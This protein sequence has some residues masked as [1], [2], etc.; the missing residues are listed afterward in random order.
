MKYCDTFCGL[1]GFSLGLRA[2]IPDAECVWAIDFDKNV[3]ET[4]KNNFGIECLGN[5]RDAKTENIPDHDI[6]FGGFPC[7]PF[8][9]NGKW[10]NKNDKTIG[11]AEDRDNLF[12]E[13]VRILKDKQ[14]KY[15]VFENV[16]GLLKMK[17]KDGT[18][19]I[20]TI[21]E[22]LVECGQGY[23][24]SPIVVDAA[25]FGVPQQRVRVFLIGI[26]KDLDQEFHWPPKV[27]KTKAIEDILES[28]VP[29]KYLISNIWKNRKIKGGGPESGPGK[30]NHPF[31]IGH[32]RHEVI[33]HIYNEA[34]KPK[35][36]THKIESVAILYGD[37]PSGLPR[38][39]D[40]IYSIKGIAPTIATFS[41]PVVDSAQGIRQLTPR[42]CA[43]LQGFPE[44]Y[45]FPKKDAAAYKQ[46]GNA[47]CVP[48]VA[49]ILKEL[50]KER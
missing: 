2:I 37:T 18:L 48:V 3:S 43:R 47:V 22:N 31:D 25:D 34:V 14:P 49:A 32:S 7:Q 5:I 27:P 44:S 42:E 24:V 16:K 23:K 45:K 10:F 38:Q 39:Q 21:I 40:K 50:L 8:S 13:L 33:N 26:R 30:K 6:I 20:R 17:N 4:F 15:F 36:K 41:T 19:C 9:R 46:I 11:D 28:D 1:G 35:T 12:L 29:A